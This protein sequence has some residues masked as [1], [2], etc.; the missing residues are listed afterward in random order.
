MSSDLNH[1]GPSRGVPKTI[2]V[3]PPPTSQ[4]AMLAGG[5]GRA[6]TAP[7]KANRPSSSALSVDVSPGRGCQRRHQLVTVL[8][9]PT[10]RGDEHLEPVD[11][12]LGCDTSQLT[13][14]PHGLPQLALRNGAGALD[15]ARQAG[16]RTLLTNGRYSAIGPRRNE[17]ADRVRADVNDPDT[18]SR[19]HS[20]WH[21]GRHR[22]CYPRRAAIRRRARATALR[23]S[24][25]CAPSGRSSFFG[26]SRFQVLS[27]RSSQA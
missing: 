1:T 6:A 10:G 23:I 5:E 8:R 25:A 7:A 22:N 2:C 11:P 12:L 26:R 17:E 18:H 4:T 21:V 14:E 19:P 24:A 27:A 16:G 13:S 3:E 15:V 20:E 9:L